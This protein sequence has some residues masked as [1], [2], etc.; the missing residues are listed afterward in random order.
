MRLLRGLMQEIASQPGVSSRE[1][2][3]P[4]AGGRRALVLKRGPR[5]FPSYAPS[6]QR[7]TLGASAG[8]SS[9]SHRRP[10]A[11]DSLPPDVRH[12]PHRQASTPRPR[13]G[14]RSDIISARPRV[15]SGPPPSVTAPAAGGQLPRTGRLSARS[16]ARCP[17]HAGR[18]RAVSEWT[19][20]HALP[21]RTFHATESS[22]GP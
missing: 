22:L 15:V 21:E 19:I 6:R 9:R 14:A 4:R 8:D 7:R 20:A 13:S 2:A 12:R 5:V 11:A 16:P 10:P 1:S 17:R 18:L 3:V